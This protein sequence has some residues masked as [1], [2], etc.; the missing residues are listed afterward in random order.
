MLP[1]VD[2]ALVAEHA[3][4]PFGRHSD[5]LEHVLA[6]LRSGPLAGKEVILCEQ[7]FE[8]YR[9]ARLTGVRGERPVPVGAE[10]YRTIEEAEH[11]VFRL[12]LELLRQDAE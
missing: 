11:A 10:V 8:R 7:P 12:R 6:H 5:R 4:D 3:A 9:L 2:D 1:L